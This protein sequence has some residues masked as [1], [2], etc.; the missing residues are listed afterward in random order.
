MYFYIAKSIGSYGPKSLSGGVYHGA[1]QRT[2]QA[3][4]LNEL[5]LFM[6]NSR[7]RLG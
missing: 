2:C 4:S 6:V 7:R 3:Y 1:A 5:S